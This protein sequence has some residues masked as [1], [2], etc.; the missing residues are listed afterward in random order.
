MTNSTTFLP[1]CS[2]VICTRNRP[3]ALERCLAALERFAYPR[4]EVLVVDNAPSDRRAMD[5]ARCR[6]VRYLVEPIAG[7][8]RARNTGARACSSDVIA[9]TDDDAV[10][11]RTWLSHLA[12]QFR[13]SSV[14]AVTGRTLML[15]DG[16]AEIAPDASDLGPTTIRLDRSQPLWFEMASFGGIGNGN[17]MAVRRR[18][19]DGWSGFDERLGRGAFLPSCEEHRAFAQ[20]IEHGHAVI[21]TPE[22]VVRHPVPTTVDER[23]EQ[24]LRS[25][26]DLAAYAV[27]L[28]CTTQHRG[29]VLKYVAQA[30]LGTRRTWRFHTEAVPAHFVSRWR[31]L[32]A[33]LSGAS[34]CVRGLMRT[35]RR[36]RL[37][38][39][40]PLVRL[41]PDTTSELERRLVNPE[42][43]RA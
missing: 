38:G 9:F 13:D 42:V 22:A 40:V 43:D 24:F 5:V 8:S 28:F 36:S 17:N 4:F 19:F 34:R 18:V 31:L 15:F 29:R 3:D 10:P 20:L 32:K 26:S 23:R 11:E 1:T 2:V 14:A 6:G 27:F 16:A 33:Y 37:F 21:Y 39:V 41:K 7:L 30:A 12:A 35:T 25:R